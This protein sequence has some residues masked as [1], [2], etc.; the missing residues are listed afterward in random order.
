MPL[1]SRLAI[2]LVGTD[3]ALAALAARTFAPLGLDVERADEGAG[4]LQRLRSQP[5]GL[6]IVGELVAGPVLQDLVRAARMSHPGTLVAVAGERPSAPGELSPALWADACF[7]SL[8]S[9]ADLLALWE[10]RGQRSAFTEIPE[11]PR[12]L[13]V[14]DD[15]LV[16][17]SVTDVLAEAYE[18]RSER[19]P[20]QALEAL[21]QFPHQVLLTDVMMDELR[22]TDLVRAAKNIHPPLVAMV[23]TGYGSKEV[24]V[25]ALREGADEFLEKPLTPDSILRAVARAWHGVRRELEISRLLQ[26]LRRANEALREANEELTVLASFADLDPAPLL[27]VDRGGRI[28]S[29]NRAA[30]EILDGDSLAGRSLHEVFPELGE[31]DLASCI[32]EGRHVTREARLADRDYQFL[33]RG[34]PE[35]GL[36]HLYS[37]DVTEL[38]RTRQQLHLSQRLEA[39]GKLAGGVAHDFN[40]LLT[41]IS[42]SINNLAERV[43]DQDALEDVGQIQDATERAIR[44]TR[45]LL[46]FSRKELIRPRV[47]QVNEVVAEMHQLLRRTVGEDIE[48]RLVLG[49]ARTSVYM[50]QGQL[51]QVLLNLV[52]N[53]RDAMPHGGKLTIETSEVTLDEVYNAQHAGVPP[54][55]YVLLAVSDSGVG[56]PPDVVSRAFE[57]F[58]TTKEQGKG[59]GMGL[60]T[61]YGVVKRAEGAVWLYS[62]VSKGTTAKVYLPVTTRPGSY[63]FPSLQPRPRDGK[64]EVILLVEDDEGV[65]SVA[66]RLLRDH[67]YTVLDAPRGDEALAVEAQYS[68]PID[69]LLTDVVM[70]GLSGKDLADHLTARRPSLKVVY[71]SGYTETAVTH[72][73][74][75]LEGVSFVHKP[76]T[77][78]ALL[79]KVRE[80]LDG[81]RRS[82]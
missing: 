33:L 51:E 80:V 48:M 6:L 21:K 7:P 35:L 67:G 24:A 66:R 19:S 44:L 52:V 61:V 54:G 38:N 12:I 37:S 45:Q 16:L 57:P 17:E 31:L 63:D 14:D 20:R 11:R 30:I 22:G 15:A 23:M 34:V 2:L 58:F 60:A 56:M 72:R 39:V 71:M 49:D 79:V 41:V 78:D 25:E 77:R 53:A 9:T 1:A 27:R 13:V 55:R 82:S 32:D 70:P 3:E 28:V 42:L 46:A 8:P 59:T 5:F 43:R 26:E 68:G 64:G 50:D 69:L 62:E 65:R 75:L 81:D 76:F 29:G 10:R 18:V 74:V 40:N 36:A 4:A 73:G 47:L